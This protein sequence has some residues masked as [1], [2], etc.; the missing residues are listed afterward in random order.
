[1]YLFSCECHPH[2]VDRETEAREGLCPKFHCGLD[3]LQSR[4]EVRAK[5]L[6]LRD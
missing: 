3:L 5:R 2:F 4:P 1:M 6:P